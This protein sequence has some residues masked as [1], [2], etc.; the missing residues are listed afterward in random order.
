MA[1]TQEPAEE[2]EPSPG[3]CVGVVKNRSEFPTLMPLPLPIGALP[4]P[5]GA[6]TGGALRG[7]ERAPLG[8]ANKSPHPVGGWG[9]WSCV[10]S[11][12]VLGFHAG[13][14]VCY[15]RDKALPHQA[16]LSDDQKNWVIGSKQR[17]GP[18]A[19]TMKSEHW[20]I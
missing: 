10:T 8:T 3:F 4:L 14:T 17:L 18:V 12:A 16:L 11:R 2:G 20:E 15:S 13:P 7:W 5:T 1:G 9:D 19:T 6:T